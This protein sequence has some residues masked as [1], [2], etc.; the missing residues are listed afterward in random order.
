VVITALALALAWSPY[1][2]HV[3]VG[4]TMCI[5]LL[6]KWDFLCENIESAPENAI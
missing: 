1:H 2:G 5:A 3:L 6:Q 4:T